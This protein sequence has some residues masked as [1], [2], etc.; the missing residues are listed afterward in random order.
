ML[1]KLI[2]Y[3]LKYA[4]KIFIL[5]HAAFLLGNIIM[6]LL[7]MD[8]IDYGA[9]EESLVISI[10]LILVLEIFLMCGVSL[11]TNLIVALR[12]YRNLFS[13]EGYLTWTLP[14]SPTE[15]LLAKFL[16]GYLL[17]IFDYAVIAAGLGILITG[18]NTANAYVKAAPVFEEYLGTTPGMYG[19][20]LFAFSAV[21]ALAV[22]MGIY[23]CIALAQ[24]LPEHRVLMA[25]A[26]YFLMSIIYQVAAV[27]IIL[28]RESS[29]GT[30]YADSTQ[31]RM[32]PYMD[33]MY[34]ILGILSLV[35]AAVQYAA[36][37]YI[38]KRKINLI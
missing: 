5:V 3:D 4:K 23:F 28:F 32:G 2:K 36:V 34:L 31:F 24:L 14:A 22:V 10:T 8:R 25:I 35:I 9:A 17:L 21:S 16:S 12:F 26:F 37:H 1:G 38:M 20:K 6:R 29:A 18:S 19:A 11:A 27:G 13:R 15:H 7:V 33:R 30:L